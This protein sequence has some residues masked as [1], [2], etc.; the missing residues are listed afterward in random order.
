[1]S[2]NVTLSLSDEIY[3]RAEQLARLTGRDLPA[4][5]ADTLAVSLSLLGPA[6]APEGP[7][8]EASDGEVLALSE[9]TMESVQEQRLSVLLDRQQTGE[10]RADERVELI[11]LMQ[12]YQEGLLRK[13]QALREAVRRGLRGPLEP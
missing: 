11:A 7:L 13:A 3:R 8:S 10:L 9:L 1:M 6:A 2:M 4:V 5:L 12:V